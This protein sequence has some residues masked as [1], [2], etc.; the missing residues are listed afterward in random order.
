MQ[1]KSSPVLLLFQIS[2]S[3]VRFCSLL[4]YASICK[5]YLIFSRVILSYYWDDNDHDDYPHLSLPIFNDPPPQFSGSFSRFSRAFSLWL[6]L[7]PAAYS[8]YCP[9]Q[10]NKL[11]VWFLLNEPRI[12]TTA[13]IISAAKRPKK[14]RRGK[15]KKDDRRPASFIETLRPLASCLDNNFHCWLYLLC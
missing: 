5:H 10:I 4:I 7:S 14:K 11:L 1:I 13:S 9:G 2:L 8:F 6:L 15:K 3:K 12:F